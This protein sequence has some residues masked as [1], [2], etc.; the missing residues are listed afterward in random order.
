[1]FAYCSFME[2]V[3]IIGLDPSL[4]A[5]GW[6][7]VEAEGTKLRHV[8]HGVIKPNPKAELHLRLREL[9]ETITDV[10]RL[11]DPAEAA[12]EEAFMKNNAA[13]AIKL[14]HARAA[15]LLASSTTGL[16]IGEYS[17]RSVKKSVVGTGTADKA[18]I[19]HMMNVLMPGCGVKA[20]DAAD[21]LAIAVCHAHRVKAAGAL[22]RRVS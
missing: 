7:V 3:R 15:C 21:A 19:A 12:V 9:F 1:M 11:H 22:Y 13:S 17:P 20:G 18:Q 5:C 10:I 8:A 14:G 6:G 2:S 4:V 16:G